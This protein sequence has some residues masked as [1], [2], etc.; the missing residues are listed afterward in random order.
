MTK[1]PFLMAT[2][3]LALAGPVLAGQKPPA[4]AP[5]RA[6][7]APA[8]QM[9]PLEDDRGARD[10]RERLRKLL[11]QYPPSVRDVLRICLR[12]DARPSDLVRPGQQV[13]APDPL[14]VD[15]RTVHAQVVQDVALG[16]RVDLGVAA[17]HLGA[18]DDNVGDGRTRESR[19]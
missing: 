14:T 16:R 4:P 13:L 9:V 2:L 10:T 11:E 17:R 3:V 1:R 12:K 5:P 7:Q 6:P 15:V 8:V 19:P 18:A